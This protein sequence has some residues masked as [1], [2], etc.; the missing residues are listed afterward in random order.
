MSWRSLNPSRDARPGTPSRST[1]PS[2]ISRNARPATSARRFQAGEPGAASGSQRL[3]ARKPAACAAAA[4]ANRRTLRRCGQA[5]RTARPAVDPGRG[6]ADEEEAVVA[7][8]AAAHEAV[9]ASR[10]RRSRRSSW[11]ACAQP[12][13]RFSDMSDFRQTSAAD[14]PHSAMDFLEPL[15]EAAGLAPRRL[16]ARRAAARRRR[17]LAH[18]AAHVAAA[19]RVPG[20]RHD[21][22][23]FARRRGAARAPTSPAS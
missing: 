9:A 22:D 16:A 4:D 19:G 17:A 18:A 5:R 3:Q 11:Q 21:P 20:R 23:A 12:V 13:W 8:V 2:A 15:A 1:I 10:S 6:D 14:P 7:R